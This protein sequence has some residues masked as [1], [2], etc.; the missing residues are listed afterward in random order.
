[1]SRRLCAAS[2]PVYRRCR[3]R[4]LPNASATPLTA[5]A[6]AAMSASPAQPPAFTPPTPASLTARPTA[7]S[8]PSRNPPS[9][10][11]LASWGRS[12]A[13]SIQNP[14]AA[15]AP[16]SAAAAKPASDLRGASG[17]PRRRRGSGGVRRPQSRPK[18]E[19]AVSAQERLGGC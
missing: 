3:A 4:G 7:S 17:S 9:Q 13:A 2:A 8:R 11:Q 14:A 15:A 19:A 1:M 12:G 6:T 5:P 18:V 16:V 10:L